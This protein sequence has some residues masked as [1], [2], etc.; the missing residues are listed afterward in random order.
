MRSDSSRPGIRPVRGCV[1]RGRRDVERAR[2]GGCLGR[3]RM[4]AGD[5]RLRV[6][7][8]RVDREACGSLRSGL[9][10]VDG[11][12]QRRSGAG[13]ARLG[14]PG[15]GAGGAADRR[16]RGCRCAGPRPVRR[17]GT[18]SRPGA[19]DRR[20]EPGDL[21][22]FRCIGQRVLAGRVARALRRSAQQGRAIRLPPAARGG[23][24][25]YPDADG[26]QRVDGPVRVRQAGRGVHAVR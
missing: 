12:G 3:A 8:G 7:R 1:R 22:P 23:R 2:A 24:R 4:A 25:G 5:L 18:S 16:D 13:D 15:C 17:R 14:S 11:E 19:G 21:E 20:G 6:L 26:R 9:F 10:G